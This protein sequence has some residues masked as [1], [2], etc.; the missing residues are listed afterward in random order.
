MPRFLVTCAHGTEGPLRR[1]LADMRIAGAK[2]DRGGVWFEGPLSMGMSVCLHARVAVRVL[3][4]LATFEAR[5]AQPS[6]PGRGPSPGP[7]G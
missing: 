4:Q 7:R 3:M 6:T 2:G 5:D 1:E